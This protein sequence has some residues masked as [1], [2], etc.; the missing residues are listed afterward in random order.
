MLRRLAVVLTGLTAVACVPQVPFSSVAV[1]LG[2]QGKI[3]IVQTDCSLEEVVSV[4]V[5][6]VNDDQILDDKDT[7][8]WQIDFKS[9]PKVRA[10]ETGVVPEGGEERVPWREPERDQ[11]LAVQILTASGM[12]LV[13]YFSMGELGEGK[14]RYHFKTLTQDEFSKE[15]PCAVK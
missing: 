10:F 6:A 2:E 1:E 7:R 9:P 13:E 8:I 15:A 11:A 3:K 5:I 4:E 12:S 14:V